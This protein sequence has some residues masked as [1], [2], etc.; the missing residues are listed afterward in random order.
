M[1]DDPT[2]VHLGDRPERTAERDVGAKFGALARLSSSLPVPPAVCI[3]WR[4]FDAALDPDVRR[5]VDAFFDDARSTVGSYV[6]ESVGAVAEAVAAVTAPDGLRAELAAA[7]DRHL[8]PGPFAVRSSAVGEDGTGGSYAGVYDSILGVGLADLPDAVEA[9][10]RSYFAPRALI[11]A[12]PGGRLRERCPHVRDR[13]GPRSGP[14]GRRRALD[15]RRGRRR[16]VRRRARRQARR[17]HGG[18]VDPPGARRSG[19][20]ASPCRPG[21][22]HGAAPARGAAGGSPG[23]HGVGVG[24]HARARRAGPT[25]RDDDTGVDRPALRGRRPV[26]RRSPA[27]GRRARG[28]P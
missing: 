10:W 28:V 5:V 11:G 21:R 8:G 16:R 2:L 20:V 3:P 14:A 27:A 7:V 6:L 15:P 18:A 22:G 17:R 26:R 4:C 23:R 1:S 12:P 13:P 24:R 19:A 9:C 25:G